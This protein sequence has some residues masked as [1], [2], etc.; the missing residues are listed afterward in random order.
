[1]RTAQRGRDIQQP[2]HQPSSCSFSNLAAA[3]NASFGPRTGAGPHPVARLKEGSRC[4][5]SNHWRRTSSVYTRK[6]CDAYVLRPFSRPVL[7]YL[8]MITWGTRAVSFHVK[9]SS[10]Q[11]PA[12]RG[13]SQAPMSV[14]RCSNERW[15]TGSDYPKRW[16]FPADT[17]PTLALFWR[18]PAR[19][20][21]SFLFR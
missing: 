17:P 21:R 9:R 11:V 13:W 15:Q 12:P 4:T 3:L 1:M 5:P 16:Y 8:R 14:T 19:D 18:F 10:E 20:T 6:D 7:T 2:I